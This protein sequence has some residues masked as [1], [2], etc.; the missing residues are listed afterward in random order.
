MSTTTAVKPRPK[1]YHLLEDSNTSVEHYQRV[2]AN[3]RVRMEKK[4]MD[5]PYLQLTY[6]DE[7][8]VNRTIRFKLNCNSPFQ[9]EQI[10]KFKIPANEKF[11]E[12]ERNM[13]WFRN[14]VLVVTNPL[15]QK[16][17]DIHPQNESF[18]GD[19]PDEPRKLFREFNPQV[20][21]QN[22]VKAFKNRS[23]LAAKILALDLDAAQSM[24]IRLNGSFY[25]PSEDI[26]ECVLALVD[27]MDT[28][29]DEE[30]EDLLRDG[31]SLEEEV[32]ILIAKATQKGLLSFD[33]PGMENFVVKKIGDRTVPLKEISANLPSD[34]RRRLFSEFLASNDGTLHLEDLRKMVD[35]ASEPKLPAASASQQPTSSTTNQKPAKALSK[36]NK[37]EL[38]EAYKNKFNEDPDEDLSNKQLI[39][40]LEKE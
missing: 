13:L 31:V 6:T 37:T 5:R 2:N 18:K 23:A 16:F 17:L 12:P 35:S 3:Q 40:L 25:K 28:S 24:L 8:G 11:T 20:K 33:E 4:K 19:C 22:D 32:T 15:A 1:I 9:D 30:V 27:I 29:S 7:G 10:E 39:A 34:D 21:T 36:M 26:E 38:T 14:G